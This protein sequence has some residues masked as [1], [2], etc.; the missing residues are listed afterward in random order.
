MFMF[1]NNRNYKHSPFS[2]LPN[3]RQVYNIIIISSS[4]SSNHSINVSNGSRD[5][6]Y[7]VG[8]GNKDKPKAPREVLTR[9]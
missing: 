4:S 1:N 5:I 7:R 9:E 6:Y 2:L 8:L 3:T